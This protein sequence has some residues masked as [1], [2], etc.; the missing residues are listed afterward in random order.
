LIANTF[1]SG[2]PFGRAEWDQLPHSF[3]AV[4]SDT[5]AIAFAEELIEAYPEA[6]VVL[7]ERDI[8]SWYDSYMTAV[9]KNMVSVH[10]PVV[11]L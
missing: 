5:P 3:G 11:D 2:T 10:S 1:G 9:I 8:D 4:S 6:K 7:V